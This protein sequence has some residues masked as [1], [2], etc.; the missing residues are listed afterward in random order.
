MIDSVDLVVGGIVARCAKCSAAMKLRPNMSRVTE[1]VWIGG[2][3]HPDLIVSG[4]FDAVLDLREN[5]PESYHREL[6]EHGIEY[7]NLP[8]R[9]GLG[10]PL[11]VL[12]SAATWIDRRSASGKVLVH[13]NLGRG[14]ASVAVAAY[15]IH[16]GS[17][18]EEALRIIKSSRWV[19]YV[20]PAQ[21]KS[22]E[23]FESSPS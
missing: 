12:R 3:N 19:M 10:V 21:R 11:G 18:P 4:G 13:C 17:C 23:E 15:L 2:V 8:V 9:D 14:R 7:M 16:V 1:K 5:V 20:N 6:I 22:L